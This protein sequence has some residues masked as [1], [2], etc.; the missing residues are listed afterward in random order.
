M[1]YGASPFE[2]GT[3]GAGV[4]S[5]ATDV[6]SKLLSGAKLTPDEL[7]W[8]QGPGYVD[9]EVMA[10]LEAERAATQK[11]TQE[12]PYKEPVPYDQVPETPTALT[13]EQRGLLPASEAGGDVDQGWSTTGVPEQEQGPYVG[14]SEQDMSKSWFDNFMEKL[15]DLLKN[16][17]KLFG[18]TDSDEY[19]TEYPDIYSW[20]GGSGGG[21]P[22]SEG[23]SG[24]GRTKNNKASNLD[25]GKLGG[26][27][28]PFDPRLQAYMNYYNTNYIGGQ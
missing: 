6:Y 16:L 24:Y 14:P 2:S 19:T 3:T 15:P 5:G 18:D 17:A 11:A 7:A 13:P 10:S 25:V 1:L 28:Y 4:Y 22:F 9:P 23:M 20:F 21:N 12:L 8:I 26:T 27:E